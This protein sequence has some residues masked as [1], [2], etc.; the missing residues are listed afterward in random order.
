V[1]SR[2]ETVL[3]APTWQARAAAHRVRMERWTLPHRE[4]R[5]RSEAHPVLDFLF[6]YYSHPAS[7]LQRW[8]PGPGV[9]LGGAGAR[10]F[11]DRTGYRETDGGV[12]VDREAVTAARTRTARWV[13]PLLEATAERGPQLSCF[14]L[15]EWAMVYRAS[16]EGVRHAQLPL[17]L[18]RSGTDAVVESL[19]LSCSHVDAFRFFTEPAR[20][21]N[22]FQPT[23]GTQRA[24]DQPGC[25]HVGMDTYKWAYRLGPFVPAELLGDCFQLAAE[26]RLLDMR[27]SPYDLSALGHTPVRIETAEGR[28]EYAQAQA[29]YARRA[30]PLRASLI[31]LYRDLLATTPW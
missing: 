21:R 7:H 15:H 9:V 5:R 11:L 26:I 12:E 27:A 22:R 30:V 10:K 2:D 6:T 28:A 8:Q 13:L 20:P 1:L 24:L 17:R 3:D 4:R 14:G 29:E 23:R 19:R 25:L 31:E 16:P 18:G